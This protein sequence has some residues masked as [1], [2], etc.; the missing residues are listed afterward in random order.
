MSLLRHHPSDF[1]PDGWA[2][3]HTVERLER[4][5]KRWEAIAYL[6]MDSPTDRCFSSF[7]QYS[8]ECAEVAWRFAYVL[9]TC[10][11]DPITF[12]SLDHCMS[13]VVNDHDDVRTIIRLY[14]HRM[15]R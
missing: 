12:D 5:P 8:D 11:G 3:R 6:S 14:G 2:I 7:G 1:A 9:S 15:Y 10:T 13:L 4:E